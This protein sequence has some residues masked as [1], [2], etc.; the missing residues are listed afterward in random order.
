M[1]RY[2]TAGESH[3]QALVGILEGLPA[4]MPVNREGIDEDLARRQQG[5]GRGGRMAIEQDR[6]HVLSGLR[7]GVTL[8]SPL[9]FTIENRDYQN[10]QQGMDPFQGDV[11]Y[12]QVVHPRPGHADL[13][14]ALKYGFDDMRPILERSSA[15]ETAARVA[16]GSI[17]RQM[18]QP[19]GIE[20]ACHVVSIG[21]AAIQHQPLTFESLTGAEN[22]PVRCIDESAATKMMAA[23]DQAK[24]QGDSLGGVV[25]VRVKGLPVGLGSHVQWDRKLDARLA[26]ALM[27]IQA[28]KGV[29]IGDGFET[30]RRPGS[31]VH[32]EIYHDK[33]RGIHRKTNHAGGIEGGM[34]NG[35]ELVVRCG[36]KP[37]PTLMQ[38]LQTIDMRTK[39]PF[40]AVKE[41][42][43][44]CAVPAAAVVAELV[45]LFVVAQAFLETFGRDSFEEMKRCWKPS[46]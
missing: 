25:E 42:S 43:D 13:P 8:A 6:I 5:Y 37:I 21:S 28:V 24:A 45:T 20:A 26:Y 30:A 3:G 22:S 33:D 2:L 32:D 10:W 7:G 12:R 14:G 39:E 19:F 34:S 17:T 15:R 27:S 35:E 46:R 16:V 4:G 40:E 38:P 9:A 41:R 29:E 1:L 18:L 31:Q 36:V 11:T 44:T 23:I